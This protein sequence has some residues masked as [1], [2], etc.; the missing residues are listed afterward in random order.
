MT[1]TFDLLIIGGGRASA[2]AIASAQAGKKVVLIERDKLGGAC[3][4]KGCVPSKLLIGFAEAARVNEWIS[5]VDSRYQTRIEN[6][7]VELIRGEGKFIGEKTVEV[8]GRK[9]TAEKIVIA[10]GSYPTPPL[11][12]LILMEKNRSSKRI[13]F[14]SRS[15][16]DHQQID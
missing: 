3:P 5:G 8:N 1:E 11:L 14:S 13:V 9:L 7:N 15:A 16:D 6:A 10:T 2:L 4:N 12:S